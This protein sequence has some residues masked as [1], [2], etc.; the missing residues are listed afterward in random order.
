MTTA[1]NPLLCIGAVDS[2]GCAGL[3]ADITTAQA[4]ASHAYTVATSL[5][6]Q[7]PAAAL[8][9]QA[10]ANGLVAAQL[11]AICQPQTPAWL[12]TAVK[13]GGIQQ[14]RHWM[15]I[16]RYL[17]AH[18]P[19]VIDPVLKTSSGFALGRHNRSWQRG[20]HKLADQAALITPNESEYEQLQM[21]ISKRT[22]VLVTGG[23]DEHSVSN[24]LLI[25]DRPI[26]TFSSPRINQELRGTGCRLATAIACSLGQGLPLERAI[27][28]GMQYMEQAIAEP[29]IL[30]AQ[31]LPFTQRF[32]GKG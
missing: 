32:E 1:N 14:A 15:L 19:V 5:T 9:S 6:V 10:V 17:P 25:N 7:T 2:A 29:H 18:I 28:N 11:R 24:Q 23:G 3:N 13:V 4:F 31:R 30:G 26:A 12:P 20:F 22:P 27:D 8:Q 21:L 16:R